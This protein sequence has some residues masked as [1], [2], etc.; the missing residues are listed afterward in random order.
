MRNL[1][2]FVEEVDHFRDMLLLSSEIVGENEYG[3]ILKKGYFDLIPL[4]TIYSD[5]EFVFIDQEFFIPNYPM[6][7]ILYRA[8]NV[9][10][11]N[12][13]EREKMLP[14]DFFWKRYE[15]IK[16]A[17]DLR[18]Y[19]DKFMNILRNRIQ[20]QKFN[21]SH[22]RNNWI[23]ERNKRKLMTVDFYEEHKRNCFRDMEEKKIVIFGAGKFADKFLAL[24]GNEYTIYK[25][26]DNNQEKWGTRL[27]GIPIEEP[28]SI[29]KDKKE[30]KVIICIK[31]YEN[32]FHQL[33]RMGVPY[34][35]IYDGKTGE[36]SAQA[37]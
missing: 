29:L 27:N 4:N 37:K 35:G 32:V 5:G 6:N 19:G 2:K 26:V 3:I 16:H 20:L 24:Y 17:D 23:M 30:C 7:A 31:D 18:I 11:D 15:M 25:I 22:M 10:Y 13:P 9:I 1:T 21:D 12:D 14:K 28:D 33:K 36:G 8:I 34:I